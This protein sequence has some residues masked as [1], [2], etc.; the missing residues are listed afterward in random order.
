MEIESFEPYHIGTKL[1][2]TVDIGLLKKKLKNKLKEKEYKV[3]DSETQNDLMLPNMETLA[4]KEDVRVMFNPL[5]HAINSVG[6]NPDNVMNVFQEVNKIILE[7]D[8]EEK[9][10][11][12]FYEIVTSI[13]IKSKTTPIEIL[14]KHSNLVLNLF[15]DCGN[16]NVIGL[17]LSDKLPEDNSEYTEVVIEPKPT[18]PN[19]YLLTSIIY[20]SQDKVKIIE[21]HNNLRPN[22]QKILKSL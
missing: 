4:T 1:K 18:S 8:Y 22:I 2:P 13:S 20:R 15:K 19:K 3:Y 16:L 11:I 6:D 5:A 21:F 9:S 12:S 10:T 14:N 17:R 7:L